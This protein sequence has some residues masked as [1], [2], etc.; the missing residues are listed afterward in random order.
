[1]I[2]ENNTE[3]QTLK[4]AMLRDLFEEVWGGEGADLHYVAVFYIFP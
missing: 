2:V 3:I 1:M 4:M